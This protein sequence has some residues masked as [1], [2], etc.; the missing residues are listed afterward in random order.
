[1]RNASTLVMMSAVVALGCG[2]RIVTIKFPD[3]DPTTDYVV[4]DQRGGECHGRR[5]EDVPPT[6]YRPGLDVLVPKQGTAG[7]CP[8]GPR[9]IEVVIKGKQVTVVGYECAARAIPPPLPEDAAD[10]SLTGGL[11]PEPPAAPE[12]EESEP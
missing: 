4:C 5:E 9:T 6:A 2:P 12:E 10:G 7:A 1:M 11:P 8:N 3:I